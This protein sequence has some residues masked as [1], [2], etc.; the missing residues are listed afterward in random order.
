MEDHFLFHRCIR[1]SFVLILG[2]LSSLPVYAGSIPTGELH[3]PQ[4]N[5]AG[6]TDGDY[7]TTTTANGGLGTSYHYW[8]EVPP[9][10]GHLVVEIFDAD[11]GAGGAADQTG[12]RDRTRG[13]YS[14]T[15]TY[16]L[17]R[18]D[19]TTAA[20]LSCTSAVSATCP[21]NA[22]VAILDSMTAQNTAAGHWELRVAMGAGTDINAIGIRA[23][24]G[25]P[26][27]GGTE[28]N[29][30]ADSIFSIG[31]HPP[32]TGTNTH[33]YTVYPYLTSGCTASEN[34]FDYDS[35]SGGTV[36]VGSLKFTSRGGGFTQTIASAALSAN[37]TWARTTLTTWTS[38]QLS[39]DY[40]IWTLAA[41]INSYNN[42]GQN[43]NYADIFLGNYQ[44]ATNPPTANPPANSFRI[45]VPTDAGG[46]PAK[47]YLSQQLTYGGC[48]AGNDGPNPPVNGST[49]C[50][51]ITVQMVNPTAQAITFSTT[52]LVTANVPGT[53]VLYAG[54]GLVSQGTI[55][56]QPAVGGS[57][58]ITWNPGTVAAGTTAT[59]SYQLKVKPTAAGQRN[60]MTGTVASGNG[61]RAQYVDETGN[62]TQTRA[63]LTFGPIC[64]LAT[65]VGLITEAVVSDVH[66]WRSEH[67]GV[68][69]EW[70]TASETGTA[71]FYLHR[72]DKTA[73]RW[74]RV[75]D[76][77]SGLLAAVAATRSAPQGGTYR[78][79]DE[80]ASP[81][82]PQIYMLEEVEAGGRHRTHGPYAL[83]VDWRRGTREDGDAYERAARPAT[84]R[85][86]APATAALK[87]AVTG[88][89]SGVHLTIRDS[90]LYRLASSDI[91]A[92]LGM[93]QKDVE[94][95]LSKGKV[96]LS[97]GGQPV[98]WQPDTTADPQGKKATGLFFYGEA[99]GSVYNAGS[100]Y[101]LQRASGNGLVMQM[102]TATAASAGDRTFAAQLH[103]EQD[104]F[105]GT[106]LDLDPESDY[107]FWDFLQADD[108]T[109]GHRTFSSDAPGLAT[110]AAS[111]TVNLQGAT[112]SGV[113]G[114]H[115]V[116]VA[117]N[118]TPLG[119]TSWQGITAQSAVFNVPAGVLL[120]SGNQISLTAEIGNGAPYSI[121][122]VNSF[123]LSYRRTLR[124]VGDVLAFTAETAQGLAVAGFS[125]PAVRLLDVSDPLHPRW[126]KAAA[127]ADPAAPGT[128][129]LGFVPQAGA[130]YL[131][132]APAAL[133]APAALRAWSVPSL[134]S[135][136]NRADYLV[137]APAA[138][139]GAAQRLANL[140]Q[141]RG[142]TTMVVT[143][144]QVFDELA[145]GVPT[146]HAFQ[147]FLTYAGSHW[148]LP[149]HYVVLAGAGS[150][151]YRNLLG[152]GDCLVPPLLVQ[153]TGG[154][155]PSDNALADANGDGIPE[156]AV[157][158]IP[159]LTEA[160]L[161]G[162]TAKLASAEAAGT[163]DW[164]HNAIF[165]SD[166]DDGDTDFSAASDQ[167]AGQ[168]GPAYTP[169]SIALRVTP[170]AAA[171]AQL[172]AGLGQGAAVVNY[173][174]HGGLDRLSAGGLLTT[175]DVAG[176]T[177]FDRLPVVT[178]MTCTISRFT[179]PGV[180]SLG[181]VLV[182]TG[183]GGAAA[184][185][186]PSGLANNAD[187]RLLAERFYHTI[188]D[189]ADLPL[190]D[191]IL[192]AYGD[193]RSLGG[194]GSLLH[195]YNL[196]GDPA[197]RL[198]HGPAAP[199][200]GGPGQQE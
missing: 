119:D 155:F 151:D 20:T 50:Y 185:W 67:G 111:L 145:A 150:L 173:M 6:T 70:R 73:R 153:S 23:H 85:G 147:S 36:G 49:S 93:Q 182:T 162:Y 127:Q 27:G 146:P 161:D 133:K 3:M 52:H 33:N 138:L 179:V 105:P 35:D 28:L 125:N 103:V 165:L 159:V 171:R 54:N 163:P 195:I 53:R 76:D 101:H 114:E 123:D 72:W 63:L 83:A 82:E 86:A 9:G 166:N 136:G 92:W 15:A 39:S 41:S 140:R 62:T 97:R 66:A 65:T 193:L 90:G 176:L 131:A 77:K 178:A 10:L 96:D 75:N 120:A 31:V 180:P 34:D 18:P 78:F 71:G 108:P 24:D 175:S 4:G 55:T 100:V 87:T 160:A 84:G 199:A 106:V 143:T 170:L 19:G 32:A 177:N 12:V 154:L 129:R 134:L 89:P 191:R 190:G 44:I 124:A 59:L 2:A 98:A 187:S 115:H 48:G 158:R 94:S 47:P 60:P 130:R 164:A 144:E 79:L 14:T 25:T 21:D 168:I 5:T 132:A 122:Y 126:I 16:T 7:V 38:D 116:L 197:L 68:Q 152:F 42:G 172:L 121:V 37:N 22:W 110:G 88:G 156:M 51:T 118:G 189:P 196:L 188:T 80:G 107:W 128:W 81:M 17:L 113:A 135:S 43:G 169:Q 69:V 30:Y 26:G 61:T 91:A 194:D 181:E 174:G 183:T 29:I 56:A 198:R 1:G 95:L 104:A 64:E 11:V 141:S 8:I 117:L 149:P 157:G 192:R 148:S 186:G 200:T 57:G 167:V 58:N 46:A 99:L 45:Y 102:Q 142:L 109:Y 137:L 40:G 139:L 74:I 184:V 112:A 13:T